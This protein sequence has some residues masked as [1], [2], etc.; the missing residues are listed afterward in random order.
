MFFCSTQQQ[1]DIQTN[2]I[3]L[4]LKQYFN[5]FTPPRSLPNDIDTVGQFS[6]I[7]E[8]RATN[9]GTVKIFLATPGATGT[10]HVQNGNLTCSAYVFEI[11]LKNYCFFYKIFVIY[12]HNKNTLKT[13]ISQ[14][15]QNQLVK[16]DTSRNIR[17]LRLFGQ[18]SPRIGGASVCRDAVY[19]RQTIL[20]W[21]DY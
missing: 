2:R 5:S 10:V 18:L 4:D 16:R 14:I 3:Q 17:N 15:L 20:H 7:Q 12:N 6:S 11:I 9:L 8:L 13:N 21:L 19:A 1:A